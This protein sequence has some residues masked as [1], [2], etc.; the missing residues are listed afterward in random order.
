MRTFNF[1][2][3]PLIIRMPGMQFYLRGW[4]RS[5]N[6]PWITLPRGEGVQE[7]EWCA[8]CVPCIAAAGPGSH[9]SSSPCPMSSQLQAPL[10][11]YL[12]ISAS[13]QMAILHLLMW[14]AT[15]TLQIGLHLGCDVT[16]IC[17]LHNKICIIVLDTTK[18]DVKTIDGVQ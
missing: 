1:P 13:L 3:L 9:V 4:R 16:A 2:R 8:V 17:L 15:V 11:S 5:E 10:A 14:I 18:I 6:T 7:Q 12:R